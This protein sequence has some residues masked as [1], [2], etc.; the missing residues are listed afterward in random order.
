MLFDETGN[1]TRRRGLTHRID[2]AEDWVSIR[3][4]R[5]CLRRPRWVRLSML[6]AVQDWS[7][8][9]TEVWFFDNAHNDQATPGRTGRLSSA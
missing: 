4:P 5:P 1:S 3:V 8:D 6:N 9:D 7:D 2:Y